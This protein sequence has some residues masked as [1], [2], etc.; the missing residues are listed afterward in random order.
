MAVPL[1]RWPT[2]AAGPSCA[3]GRKSP[4]AIH[5]FGLDAFWGHLRHLVAS[6]I[7][8]ENIDSRQWMVPEPPSVLLARI[9]EVLGNSS[10]EETLADAM[11]GDVWIDFVA[12]TGDDVTVSEKV[13]ELLVKE[14]EVDG[15]T[16]P[17]ADILL[18]GGDLAYPV[19]TVLEITRRL[20]D[21]WNRVFERPEHTDG[22]PRVLLAVPGNHDWYDGLDGFA[23]LCQ[24]PLV[25]EKAAA[26]SAD[27]EHPQPS[28]HPVLAWAEAFA[29]GDAVRKPSSL[30]LA[31][32][33]PVQRASYFRLA[34][35]PGLELFAVDR[36]LK[37][38]DARQQAFFAV[39]GAP[40]RLV[41][42]PD[43][44]RAWGE[45]RS[46]GVATL[47]SLGIDMA[48]S[49][50]CLLAGDIHHYERSHEGPSIHVV[51]GGGG[52]FLHGARIAGGA[53]YAIEAE[54]PGKKAS[55]KLLLGLPFH[56]ATGRSGSVVMA[57]FGLGDAAALVEQFRDG[58]VGSLGVAVAMS[59]VVG[60]GTAVLVGWRARGMLKMVPF[61]A[62]LGAAVGALP[63]ALGIGA[64]SLAERVVGASTVG[65]PVAFFIAL[66]LATSASCF[67]FGAML[68]L[69]ARMGLNH[70][71]AYAA[72][73]SSGYKHFVRLR[74]TRA[75]DRSRVEAWAIGMVDP[76]RSADAVLVDHFRFDPYA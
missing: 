69:I 53:D 35:A 64:D 66:A 72:L 39:P 7:A 49:P 31:G 32:Y 14:Y 21:P 5:W 16:L 44:A 55:S 8:T 67:L 52:A 47:E 62:V 17:R 61:A 4:R 48:T 26:L 25:F 18:L 27:A 28:M 58:L 60:I 3:R 30:A 15:V 75:G 71:Q 59:A 73:G 19:A 65:R 2:D 23:R 33:Q 51:A 70:A 13:A 50:T 63:V 20:V 10:G 37:R 46:H 38:V 57:I 9:L 1:A 6:A 41:V 40:A 76:V 74:V 24:A 34:L 12:D 68:A 11:G 29:R 45:D 22:K 36:Q 54:F 56:C 42:V 43:P